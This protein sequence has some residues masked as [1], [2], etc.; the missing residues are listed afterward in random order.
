MARQAPDSDTRL[1]AL[2]MLREGASIRET[3]RSLGLSPATVH[4]WKAADAQAPGGGDSS[5][6]VNVRERSPNASGERSQPDS[7]R[8]RTFAQNEAD[9]ERPPNAF[10]ALLREKDSRIADL[11]KTVAALTDALSDE[12]EARRRAD[13][14]LQHA[15]A[16]P[17]LPPSDGGSVPSGSQWEKVFFAVVMAALALLAIALLLR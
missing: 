5:K 11:R 16:R 2:E 13:V 17:S 7:E 6:G 4:K 14:M 12:R 3:A 9:A 10:E 15:L 8:S 1:K